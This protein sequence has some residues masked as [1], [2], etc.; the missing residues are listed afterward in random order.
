R[1]ATMADQ[2]LRLLAADVQPRT[3]VCFLDVDGRG[4]AERRDEALEE[5]DDRAG[6]VACHREITADDSL[7]AGGSICL[8]APDTLHLA[9]RRRT[10][11]P[12][13]GR[14]NEI[15][16][17]VLLSDDP[18]VGDAIVNGGARRQ[19]QKHDREDHRH[20]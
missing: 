12:Y 3:V 11:G 10:D 2:E 18:D 14:A 20:E 9:L 16:R 8:S 13:V 7:V 5:L 1:L 6:N 19:P 17:Q 4:D 15:V